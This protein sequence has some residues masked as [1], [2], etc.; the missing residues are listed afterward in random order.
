MPVSGMLPAMRYGRGAL[1]AA[2]AACLVTLAGPAAA[3]AARTCGPPGPTWPTASPAQAGLDQGDLD[4]ALHAY[5]DRRSFAVRIYRHGCLV[6]QDTVL[7]STVTQHESWEITSSVLA[8]VALR[9]R[10]QG[11]LDLDDRVGAL[12]SEADAAH[13]AIT[14]RDLLQRTS[15][16]RPTPDNAFREN[17]LLQALATPVTRLAGA[18]FGDAPAAR[19]LLVAV[20]E[21]AAGEDLQRYAARELFG[22]VG[23][24][25]FSW[26]RDRRGQTRGS[27][28]LRLTADDLARLAELARLGGRW[29]DRQLLPADDVAEMLSPQASRCHGFMTWVNAAP[30]CAGD[31]GRLLPGL[32]ADLWSWRGRFDQR[33]VVFPALGLVV[34]RYGATGGD[35]RS[36]SDPRAWERGVLERLIAAVRDTPV[37]R[38]PGA[39]RLPPSTDT[40]WRDDAAAATAG[41]PSPPGPGP[42]RTRVPRVEPVRTT[43]GRS[44][45]VSVRISCPAIGGVPCSGTVA[46]DGARA[47]P[48]AWSVPRG[49]HREVLLRLRRRPAGPLDVTFRVTALDDADGVRVAVPARLTR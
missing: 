9:Q 33:V 47:R 26:L 32:P 18:A 5:Q 1:G 22:P 28:G 41:P 6:A 31:D 48:R 35:A 4:L 14:V 39:D 46:L 16:I 43:V 11:L 45:L 34:V 37:M 23:I 12:L 27:F 20:L 24:A 29:G 42:R 2:V 3:Q 15:G 8:L 44:R 17:V 40:D 13:G 25:R 30:G 36:G 21:R 7:G 19:D 38:T 10:A 49:E